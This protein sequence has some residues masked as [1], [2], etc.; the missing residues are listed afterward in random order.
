LPLLKQQRVLGVLYLENNLIPAVFNPE[1]IELTRLLTAQAAIALENTLL[2]T[3]MQCN[4]Q[5]MQLFN[6]LLETRATERT[7]E[8][9]KVNEELRNFAYIVSH[10]LKAPLRAINQLAAWIEEDYADAFDEDGKA[11]MSL[12]RSRAKRMHDMI[13]GI[14]QYSRIGRVKEAVELVDLNGLVADVIEAISP[15]AQIKIEVQADLPCVYGEKLR[16]YQVLQNLIDNAIKYNDKP[17]GLVRLSCQ[18]LTGFKNLSGLNSNAWCFCVQDNGMGIDKPYQEKVFQLFQT[19]AP[20]D[21][22]NSTGIGL[23]LVEKIVSH[24]GG[25]LWLESE[26]GQGCGFFFTIPKNV[27]QSDE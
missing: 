20:K 17:Q 15:P 7:Q 10:D 12:L 4:Q 25:K 5:Q 22:Q 18:D 14:L 21:H 24:W 23:S 3:E 27:E 9:N 13:E 1:H 19:L 11:Q 8:L 6:E 2:I 26:L 16:I